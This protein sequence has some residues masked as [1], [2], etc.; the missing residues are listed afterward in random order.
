MKMFVMLLAEVEQHAPLFRFDF[1]ALLAIASGA[2]AILT[3]TLAG[4]DACTIRT[5]KASW[6]VT[7]IIWLVWFAAMQLGIV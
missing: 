2:W 6:I 5:V 3:L 1:L 7:V 4:L